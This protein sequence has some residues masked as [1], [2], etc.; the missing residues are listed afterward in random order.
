[1]VRNMWLRTTLILVA[2]ALSGCP[3]DEQPAGDLG[4]PPVDAP[5]GPRDGGGDRPQTNKDQGPSPKDLS[6]TDGPATD[7]MPP[8]ANCLLEEIC[9]HFVNQATCKVIKSQCKYRTPN[10]YSP[11]V[12]PCC[13]CQ[14]QVCGLW[15]QCT[16]TT[17]SGPDAGFDP[18]VGCFCYS[19]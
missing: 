13:T 15:Y 4:G 11:S 12:N 6:P 1:M 19:K 14:D 5:G 18:F 9:V 8:C 17:C 2:L 7:W 16:P 10:C 3:K